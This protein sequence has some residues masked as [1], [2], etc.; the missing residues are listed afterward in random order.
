MKLRCRACR[1]VG[2]FVSNSRTRSSSTSRPPAAGNT[3]SS[4]MP[5]GLCEDA[6]AM[7]NKMFS[8]PVTF[9]MISPVN[10]SLVLV[11]ARALIRCTVAISRS[12]RVSVI[13]R[14]RQCR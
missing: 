5:P 4:T 3:T 6:E 12:A 10:C 13:S 14:S 7:R 2:P 11:S 8:L 9:L 1:Y